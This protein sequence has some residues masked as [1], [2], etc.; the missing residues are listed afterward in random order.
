VATG[1]IESEPDRAT[2]WAVA[3]SLGDVRLE[4]TLL[5]DASGAVDLGYEQMFESMELT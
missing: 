1:L 3:I 4:V 2:A 5:T